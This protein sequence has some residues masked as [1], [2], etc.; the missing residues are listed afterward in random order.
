MDAPDVAWES[1]LDERY[2][3]KVVRLAPYQGQLQI[4]DGSE[5]LHAEPV[6]LSYDALFG[7]D[8]GDVHQWQELA[9]RFIDGRG[10]TCREVSA[11]T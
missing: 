4:W 3:V 10:N 11:K 8:V 9:V 7:P 5:L 6:G 1:E 2:V